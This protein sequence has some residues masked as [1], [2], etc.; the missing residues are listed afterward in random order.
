M[1]EQWASQRSNTGPFQQGVDLMVRRSDCRW[2]V[3]VLKS[4]GEAVSASGTHVSAKLE[5]DAPAAHATPAPI[6]VVI[7]A[8]RCP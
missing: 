6:L 2:P 5:A 3:R 4:T 7:R 1:G 8:C